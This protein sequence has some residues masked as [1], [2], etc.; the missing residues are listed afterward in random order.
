[1]DM[2]EDEI[3]NS[4]EKTIL[5]RLRKKRSNTK[6]KLSDYSLFFSYCISKCKDSEF[7]KDVLAERM[8]NILN[9][10]EITFKM[11]EWMSDDALNELSN[12]ASIYVNNT[13]Y[14]HIYTRICDLMNKIKRAYPL[15]NKLG[16]W[17]SIERM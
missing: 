6:E 12:Y 15:V 16:G 5:E 13:K 2:K 1:M 9:D 11:T 14:S 17:N 4:F 8:N 10:C 7:L 3:Y